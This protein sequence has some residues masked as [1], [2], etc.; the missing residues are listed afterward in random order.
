[1]DGV[2]C[3]LGV[4]VGAL[5]TSLRGLVGRYALYIVQIASNSMETSDIIQLYWENDVGFISAIL[6]PAIEVP[7]EAT[8]QLPLIPTWRPEQEHDR[9]SRHVGQQKDMNR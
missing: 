1:M 6:Q 5:V 2:I 4:T 7:A 3:S 8:Y 9:V